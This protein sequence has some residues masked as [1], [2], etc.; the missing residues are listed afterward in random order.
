[1]P[2]RTALRVPIL[3]T[4]PGKC[5]RALNPN[6][7]TAL[8]ARR[9]RELRAWRHISGA[10]RTHSLTVYLRLRGLVLRH[11]VTTQNRLHASIWPASFIT[12]VIKFSISDHT[13]TETTGQGECYGLFPQLK[14]QIN[15]I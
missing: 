8:I 9:K 11:I 12:K 7:D 13:Q 15:Q 14:P 5:S 1:M 3:L 4:Q 6:Q 2:G 10:A